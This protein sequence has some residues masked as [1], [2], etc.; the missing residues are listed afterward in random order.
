MQWSRCGLVV[1]AATPPSAVLI[2]TATA[3]TTGVT[4]ASHP[5]MVIHDDRRIPI[6]IL[7]AQ[8]HVDPV[9]PDPQHCFNL[10]TYFIS[11]HASP[12]CSYLDCSSLP[13]YPP[14][15]P[16][17]VYECIQPITDICYVCV[18]VKVHFGKVTLGYRII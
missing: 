9:D 18:C 2:S 15:P 14:P 7:E 12:K 16:G 1:V 6:R 13:P 5:S 11:G 3:S 10:E 17:G 8:K 4:S